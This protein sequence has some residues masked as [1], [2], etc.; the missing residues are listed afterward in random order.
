M[1]ATPWQPLSSLLRR[2]GL[3]PD[4]VMRTGEPAPYQLSMILGKLRDSDGLE[5]R[6]KLNDPM[7]SWRTFPP[8]QWHAY[9]ALPNDQLRYAPTGKVYSFAQVR[10]GTAAKAPKL[11]PMEQ[12]IDLIAPYV[13][14]DLTAEAIFKTALV[15]NPG[16]KLLMCSRRTRQEAVKFALGRLTVPCGRIRF[17][18]SP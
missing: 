15:D 14:P 5:V 1:A 7:G 10:W 3:A 16:H 4:G 8:G 18:T 11:P 6:I 13:K 17:V 2:Y 12:R 9:E